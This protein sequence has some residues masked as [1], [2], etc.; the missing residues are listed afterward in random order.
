LGELKNADEAKQPICDAQL[1][2]KRDKLTKAIKLRN[3]SW[4]IFYVLI[5]LLVLDY[6]KR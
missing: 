1:V 4:Y 2:M 5:P 3:I 6:E